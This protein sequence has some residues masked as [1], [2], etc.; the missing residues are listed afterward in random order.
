[1]CVILVTAT[2]LTFGVESGCHPI[3]KMLVVIY[4]GIVKVENL[5]MPFTRQS[6]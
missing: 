6:L 2:L 5:P 1:M 3:S 4:L